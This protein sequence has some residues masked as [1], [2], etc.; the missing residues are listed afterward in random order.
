LV[1]KAYKEKKKEK[2]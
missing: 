2:M 1:G